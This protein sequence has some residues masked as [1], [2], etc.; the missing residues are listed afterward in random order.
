MRISQKQLEH[1]RSLLLLKHCPDKLPCREA[2]FEAI[3]SL[4][5]ESLDQKSGSCIFISGVPGTGKTA[6]ATRVIEN[7]SHSYCFVT[8]SLNAL[9]F[10]DPSQA[11]LSLCHSLTNT[12]TANL[13]NATALIESH[14]N[15]L[16]IPLVLLIDEL[17]HMVTRSQK[18]LYNLFDWPN[19]PN[20]KFILVAIANTMDLPERIFLNKISSRVGLSR[21]NFMPYKH[22][23]LIIIIQ[24]RLEKV[25][26]FDKESIEFISRN[27]ASVSGD[28]RRAL[29]ICRYI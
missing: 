23:E 17:D 3:E 14:L 27:V 28:A 9:N 15:T 18:L 24:S 11:I 13:N 20:S 12:R 5:S 1:A 21:V 19:R 16:K 25:K 26:F 6:T 29:E 22:T 10:T 2:E 7:L 8:I 4:I